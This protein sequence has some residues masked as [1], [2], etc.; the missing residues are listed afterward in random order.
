M[1][2]PTDL[3]IAGDL[4]PQLLDEIRAGLGEPGTWDA[5]V[6]AALLAKLDDYRTRLVAAEADLLNV[7]GILSPNG[8][9]RRVP[10]ELVP[11]VAPAVEW[12]VAE[13]ERLRA[14]AVADEDAENAD[15]CAQDTRIRE[16][17][18]ENAL[19]RAARDDYAERIRNARAEIAR[20]DTAAI[21]RFHRIVSDALAPV[22]THLVDPQYRPGAQAQRHFSPGYSGE[23]PDHLGAFETCPMPACA[24]SRAQHEAA[25]DIQ[26]LTAGL[27]ADDTQDGA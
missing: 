14:Q 18:Q 6:V 27:F 22:E 12:L 2:A 24:K 10:V 13:V 19:L 20:Q 9:Q 8:Q 15:S 17:E 7:R 16:L 1:A 3:R 21:G 5:T 11:T 4:T 25:A 26:Q 23:I